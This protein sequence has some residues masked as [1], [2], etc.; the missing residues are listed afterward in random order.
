MCGFL[1]IEFHLAASEFSLHFTNASACVY[2][3][4]V[5]IL[6]THMLHIY[7]MYTVHAR[8]NQP[9]QW[10]DFSHQNTNLLKYWF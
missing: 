2:I 1:I 7:I 8:H 6:T 3:I 10:D 4:N 9:P 5:G